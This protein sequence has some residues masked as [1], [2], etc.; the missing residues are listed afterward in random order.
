MAN[1]NP[2]TGLEG[3]TGVSAATI[4]NIAREYA[5]IKPSALLANF[6][7]GRT[8]YGEQYHRATSTL[9]AMTGNVGVHGGDAGAFGFGPHHKGYSKAHPFLKLGRVFNPQPNPVELKYGPRKNSFAAG[10]GTAIFRGGHVNQTAIADA[11]LRGKAG[12]YPADYKLAYVVSTSY[13][14]QYPNINRCNEA[15]K[16]KTLEFTVVFEQFMTPGAK[17]ADIILPINSCLE[18]NDIVTGPSVGG[19]FY[20]FRGKAIDSRGESKSHLEICTALA[21]RLG[22]SDYCDKTEE[23]LLKEIA[24]RIPGLLITKPSRRLED[25]SPRL[26]NRT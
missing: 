1:Q 13:P 7:A 25:M 5:N 19:G 21:Q 6:S 22:I 3:I 2:P 15:L 24:A 20:G 9:A 23:E 16:S 14:N 12:G 18:R 10:G 4:E 11:I 26:M 17:F 8:A